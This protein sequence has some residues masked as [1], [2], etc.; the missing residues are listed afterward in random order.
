[1]NDEQKR[2]EPH[3]LTPQSVP[4]AETDPA[5]ESL[6]EA[7]RLSFKLLSFIMVLFVVLFLLTGITS[8]E[9]QE[10]GIKKVFGRV[11]GV[12]D[13]GFTYNWPFPIGE[14]EKVNTEEQRV[15]IDT[16]WMN[17]TAEDKARALADRRRTNEGLQ[18]GWDGYLLTADRNLIHLKFMATYQVV[19]PVAVQAAVPDLKVALESILRVQA[20]QAGATRTASALQKTHDRF[21]RDIR[22][23]AQKAMDELL[24]SPGAVVIKNVL[25][26]E[27]QKIWPLAAWDAYGDTQRA[28]LEMDANIKAALG[29]AR[30]ILIETVGEKH[31]AELVAEPSANPKAAPAV[32]MPNPTRENLIGQYGRVRTEMESADSGERA[33]LQK[34]AD[35]LL[36]EIN[37]VLTS[38]TASGEVSKRMAAAA[39]AAQTAVNR[40]QRRAKDFNE[41]LADYRKASDVF[42][43][44][45]FANA[46]DWIYQQPTV[47]KYYL[48]PGQKVLRLSPDPRILRRIRDIQRRARLGLQP[49]K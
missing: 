13:S 12:V 17:E 30:S 1:M 38:V 33:T 34:Q 24:E 23:G 45:E 46:M 11:T 8:I 25:I 20:V 37:R 3:R 29:Q 41:R 48:T 44:V 32:K 19:S 39:P 10:K 28:S 47:T 36:H 9:A 42:L 21:C 14:I 26:P 2:T 16:F 31:Y 6:S 7:L 40:A 18:P 27:Q 4:Q 35:V 5:M 15:T 22:V 43:G 49:K